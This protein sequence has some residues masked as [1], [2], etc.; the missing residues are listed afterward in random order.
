MECFL[1]PSGKDLPAATA[2]V[3]DQNKVQVSSAETS[4][5]I[6]NT[7]GMTLEKGAPCETGGWSSCSIVDQSLS[8]EGTSIDEGEHGDQA[9]RGLSVEVVRDKHVSSIVSDSTVGGTDGAEAQVISKM[10]SSE[11][12]GDLL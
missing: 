1:S 7:S 6:M 11:A 3:S 12:A 9:I 8:M 2:A 4:F 5:S 10:V